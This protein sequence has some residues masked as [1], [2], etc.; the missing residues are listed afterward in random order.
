MIFQSFFT[1][2]R[3]IWE[4]CFAMRS[5]GRNA[6]WTCLYAGFCIGL[7]KRIYESGIY[8]GGNVEDY[9]YSI[10][11]HV[12]YSFGLI[13]NKE[14]AYAGFT[15]EAWNT[16]DVNPELEH[17]IYVSEK[18]AADM[19]RINELKEEQN[20]DLKMLL[21]VGGWGARGFTDAL[22]PQKAARSLHNPARK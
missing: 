1:F 2:K 7:R 14:Y 17:T 12:N 20:P 10:V 13:Y 4:K 22:Q 11:T 21:S 15:K 8:F 9:D 5:D 16:A 18:A 3:R 6:G 19:D